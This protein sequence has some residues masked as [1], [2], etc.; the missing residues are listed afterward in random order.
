VR[1]P[2]ERVG[3]ARAQVN[4][5]KTGELLLTR[6]LDRYGAD[7]VHEA[8]EEL[9][10]HAERQ[11]RAHIAEVPDGTYQSTT[12]VDSDGIVDEPLEVVL[13]MTVQGSDI[14]FD[15]SKSS[16]LC[17]GPL[18]S[19]WA[20]T[21]SAVYVAMRHIFPDVPINA[22]CFVPLHIPEPRGTFLYSEFPRPVSGCAA[23]TAQR[24]QE[25]VFRAMGEAIPDRMFASPHGSSG[26]FCLGGYD[27]LYDRRFVLY[28]F[29]GGGFGGWW[30][31]DGQTNGAPVVGMSKTQPMEV[32]EQRYPILVDEYALSEGSGGAGKWRGGFGV[33]YRMRLARGTATAAFLM[34]HGRTG[35]P[36]LSGGREGGVL[37]IRVCQHGQI[38]RPPHLSKGDGYALEPGDWVE[39]CTAGGGG[40]GDPEQREHALIE[41]DIRRGYI[42][43]D[44]ARRDYGYNVTPAGAA[45]G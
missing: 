15:F 8:V 19:V 17:A 40:Y 3:D 25:S 21:Q 35:P 27:P 42:T 44:E 32:L 6:F 29:S 28:F 30:G 9:R 36:G 38:S 13:E 10:A 39:V 16:G 7:T 24:V 11:M 2:D 37:R 22:G 41:Q 23:E 31:G 14:E 4:G 26:N 45:S 12:Y 18:N 1:V 43:A 5:L 20:T 34:D 33:R